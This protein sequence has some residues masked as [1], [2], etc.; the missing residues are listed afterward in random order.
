MAASG[1][2]RNCVSTNSTLS[3]SSVPLEKSKWKEGVKLHHCATLIRILS[4][5]RSCRSFRILLICF[6]DSTVVL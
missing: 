2:C 3:W 1:V 6:N 5:T 4:P